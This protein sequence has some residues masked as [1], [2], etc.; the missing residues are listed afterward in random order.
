MRQ[1]YKIVL[2]LL[3]ITISCFASDTVITSEPVKKACKNKMRCQ[4]YKFCVQKYNAQH[5]TSI[6]V[7]EDEVADFRLKDEIK[8]LVSKVSFLDADGALITPE[9]NPKTGNIFLPLYKKNADYLLAFTVLAQHDQPH[10]MP[11]V[12]GIVQRSEDSLGLVSAFN[13]MKPKVVKDNV[14]VCGMCTK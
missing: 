8:T 5:G 11:K 9:V 7:M 6:P 2:N 10:L 4:F 13:V 1:V 3:L 12:K 14:F